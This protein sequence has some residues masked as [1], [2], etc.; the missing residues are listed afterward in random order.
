[1]GQMTA[2][3]FAQRAFDL[4]L[5]TDR[6][7]REAWAA[8]GTRNVPLE[9]FV[10]Y[11]VGREML[12]NYQ[13]DKI[14]KGDKSGFFYGD[15]KVLYLV[16]AG[17]F[18]RV[19]RAVH[20][21][22]GQV[23]ALKVLRR[24]Y[25][26]NPEQY[27]A[28][29][30]EGRVGLTLRHPNI[31]PIYEVVSEGHT[32]YLVMEFVEGQN[33]RDFVK[34]R[35]RLSP[36]EATR[37]MCDIASG[38]QYAFEHGLT[39]RD[40]KMTNVLVSSEG[41]A[42]LVDFGLAAV[43]EN[44]DDDLLTEF[45]N[46]RTI[47]YAGLERATGVRKDDTRSDIYF[48]GCIYYH[49][50][51]GRPPLWETKD[52]I[53]RL[54]KQRFLDVQ[55]IQKVFPEV[56]SCVA[57]VVNKAMSLDVNRRY[58]TPAAMLVDLKIAAKRL[59]EEAEKG[60]GASGSGKAESLPTPKH[61]IMVVESNSRLQDLFRE[62]LKKAGFRVLLTSDPQRALERFRDEPST[63]ECLILNAQQIGRP[64]LEVFN[65]FGEETKIQHVPAILLLDS[66]QQ[67]WKA[68]ANTGAHRLVLQMPITVRQLREAIYQ[69]LPQE[70]G[71]PTK[72]PES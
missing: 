31:V 28:F 23:V 65:Q 11:L 54:S 32:H 48:A 22:T 12:T 10:Q 20:R 43:D 19:F 52:R 1:M 60:P 16:G 45:A 66:A 46:P 33:L 24:R 50:L 70:S 44:V 42:K 25:S 67:A 4:G 21:E 40:L 41:R 38:L 9:E 47:D 29:L 17:T 6:Q 59:R 37:L 58:Q 57:L 3:Q 5:I 71:T 14:L 34:V 69:L 8:F 51:T 15:Y 27:E 35:G 36:E 7:L 56:P 30:R 63:A 49:M 62:Q 13:V 61:T 2:E 18:A 72:T 64:A 55:P 26:D 68:E 39:H 53:Q